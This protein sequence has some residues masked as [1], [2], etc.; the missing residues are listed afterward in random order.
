MKLKKAIS[1]YGSKIGKKAE[2][3]DHSFDELIA[4]FADEQNGTAIASKSPQAENLE[5]EN[6]DFKH[7]LSQKGTSLLGALGTRRAIIIRM[8]LAGA[9]LLLCT[10]ANLPFAGEIAIKIVAALIVG[11]D[12][13]L[14]AVSD[15]MS[16]SFVGSSIP[17]LV[18]AIIYICI[19]RGTEAVLT[20]IIYHG[21]LLAWEF[22]AERLS[23]ACRESFEL[24]ETSSEIEGSVIDLGEGMTCP[25][26]CVVIAGTG[27][28][29]MSFITGDKT[30]VNLAADSFIPAGAVMIRGVLTARIT[31]TSEM[32]MASVVA[33]NL[34]NG[35]HSE[36]AAKSYTNTAAKVIIFASLAIAL[37]LLL[38][39]PVA[40]DVPIKNS[41]ARV[42]SVIAL[43]SPGSLLIATPLTF[44]VGMSSAR[45]LGIVF[46]KASDLEKTAAIKSVV[47]DKAGTLTGH[48]YI[49]SEIA[50]DKMDPQTFLKVA[51]YA[52]ANSDSPI[53]KAIVA[54]YG[55]SISDALVENYVCTEGKGVSVTVDGIEIILGSQGY[56]A[57][58]GISLPRLTHDSL[59]VHMTVNGIY[60]GRIIL[61]DYIVH[62]ANSTVNRLYDCGVERIT[63]MSA[64]NRERDLAISKELGID[65][66]I[67]EC[68]VAD[69]PRR[70]KEMKARIDPR[71]KLAYVSSNLD[72]AP[73]FKAADVGISVGAVQQ[74]RLMELADVTIMAATPENT[75]TA[76]DIAL[77]VG[78]CLRMELMFTALAKLLAVLLAAFG[79]IPLWL[80]V[81]VDAIASLGVILDC[82][83]VL[84]LGGNVGY[85]DF[86][87]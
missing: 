71:S 54:A 42:A 64:D 28:A 52:E 74:P 87:R 5:K 4:Q 41:L 35:S 27:T 63:M 59:A 55:K 58:K 6:P 38:F 82:H 17:V 72:A 69:R 76:F 21:A 44:F 75:A 13:I 23:V 39:L 45:R 70:I 49:V 61:S 19:S 3:S 25:A 26:D 47:F 32:S 29:D 51:A 37:V 62:S 67:A 22:A 66:Y 79:F 81:L 85:G 33:R 14:K 30:S 12:L 65:E 8:A 50:S 56:L 9:L 77:G 86:F 80:A 2:N 73:C 31:A 78:R 24:R 34:Q 60:A 20:L 48:N 40:F 10:I 1:L 18:A 68:S 57:E 83:S 11:Y 46:K 53:A 16:R 7:H 15:V 84:R 36:T 43:A